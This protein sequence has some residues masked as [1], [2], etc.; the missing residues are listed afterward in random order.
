MVCNLITDQLSYIYT[1]NSVSI[2]RI[3]CIFGLKTK[4]SD[5][6]SYSS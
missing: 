2:L 1:I 3:S 5:L 4:I 6:C